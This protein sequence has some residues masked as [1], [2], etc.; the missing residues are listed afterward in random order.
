MSKKFL[1]T[2]FQQMGWINRGDS[3]I[4]IDVLRQDRSGRVQDLLIRSRKQVKVAVGPFR[5]AIN[6]AAAKNV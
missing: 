5:N 4:G 2:C 6:Q 1:T 3:L